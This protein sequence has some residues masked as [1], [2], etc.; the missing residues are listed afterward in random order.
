MIYHTVY[1]DWCGPCHQIAPVYEEMTGALSRPNQIT[2]TKI[3]VDQQ[4]AI[5]QK[6]EVT[7]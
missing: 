4:P 1:A 2:F 3:N 5:A 6:Y 7:G